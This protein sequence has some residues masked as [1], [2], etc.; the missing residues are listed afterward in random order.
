[1]VLNELD[2]ELERRGLRFVRYADDCN[3]FVGS[4]RA[5]DRVMSSI[6]SFLEK[7][8]RLQVNTDKSAVRQPQ[9][10]HFLGFR[11][12]RHQEKGWLV[13]LS[14]KATDRIKAKLKEM[15]PRTWGQS[16]DACLKELNTYIEGWGRT[17]ESATM[18]Q[19]AV[20]EDS[21]R[22]SDDGCERLPSG[23]RSDP[24]FYFGIWFGM[25]RAKERLPKRR[26]VVAGCGTRVLASGSIKRTGW[27]GSSVA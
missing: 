21:T 2:W 13:Y 20:G 5:G 22:T 23:S 14:H 10:V 27:R 26:G 11:F 25:G 6:S 24:G 3:I 18:K 16:V 9:D 19:S 4:P 17:F 15:T 7:R 12:S 8:L 1:M